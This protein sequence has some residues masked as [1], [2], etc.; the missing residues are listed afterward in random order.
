MRSRPHRP[1]PDPFW[2]GSAIAFLSAATA[3]ADVR[4]PRLS[5]LLS[6]G[7]TAAIGRLERIDLAPDG[8]TQRVE[9]SVQEV[10]G[11]GSIPAAIVL[12]WPANDPEGHEVAAGQRLFLAVRPSSPGAPATHELAGVAGAVVPVSDTQ[13]STIRGLLASAAG[14]VVPVGPALTVLDQPGQ[15]LP[16]PLLTALLEDLTE[17]L[18]AAHAEAIGGLA[19][20]S[21]DTVTPAVRHWALENVGRTQSGAGL[22]CARTIA[23]GAVP[24]KR[25]P[26][27]GDLLAALAAVRGLAQ[28]PSSITRSTLKT[29]IKLT[30]KPLPFAIGENCP[31]ETS[32]LLAGAILGVGETRDPTQ[33]GALYRAALKRPTRSVGNATVHAI[34]WIGGTRAR[35]YLERLAVKHPD[36][37]IRQQALETIPGIAG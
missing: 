30:L 19:C 21:P 16:P 4:V 34:G 13:A 8:I 24:T 20:A 27:G 28:H 26:A 14:G 5:E 33:V 35:A 1:K 32:N 10:L 9:I 22:T 12:A 2:F 31:S 36:P 17:Q 29:V 7:A 11:G 3:L 18:N 6:P 15:T 37:R 25:N 23:I